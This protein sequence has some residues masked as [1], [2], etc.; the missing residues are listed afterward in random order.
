[1][2]ADQDFN[3][4]RKSASEKFCKNL[5]HE[6]LKN[7]FPNSV[8]S[9]DSVEKKDEPPDYFLFIDGTKYAVEVTIVVETVDIGA[10][11]PL[12]IGK[13]Q[14]ELKKFIQDKVQSVAQDNHYLHGLYLVTFPKPI[15]SLTTVKTIIQNKLLTYIRNTKSLSHAP[16]ERIWESG[17]EICII[18]KVSDDKDNAVLMAGPGASKFPSQVLADASQL[19]NKRIQEKEYKLRNISF[20]KVLLLHNKDIFCTSETFKHSIS[21]IPSHISF[22]SVFIVDSGKVVLLYS[23]DPKWV[24]H[25]NVYPTP[26]IRH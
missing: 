14:E 2:I 4:S 17:T 5:F 13:I 18:T 9:W 1:M 23:Q 19:L 8:I 3:K 15:Y 25:V 26:F 7:H 6:F 12:P 24:S 11:E 10:N 22:H 21:S 20:P 16:S